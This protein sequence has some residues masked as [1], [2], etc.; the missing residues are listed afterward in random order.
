M[1]IKY[2]ILKNPFQTDFTKNLIRDKVLF[3]AAK[4][5]ENFSAIF[6]IA[7]TRYPMQFKKKIAARI[8]RQHNLLYKRFVL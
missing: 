2:G 8:L 3:L 5:K 6:N 1:F 7:A 4:F